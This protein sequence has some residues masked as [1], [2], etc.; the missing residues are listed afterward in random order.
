MNVEAYGQDFLEK[1][2]DGTVFLSSPESKGWIARQERTPT[3]AEHPG[4]AVRW[5]GNV[6][7]VLEAHPLSDGRI[8][9]KL[10]PWDF[11]HAIRVL[12]PYDPLAEQQRGRERARRQDSIWKRR[13]AILFSP[14]LGHLPGRVQ[15]Q[16]ESEFGAPAVAMTIVS[17]LPLLA[18]GV[19]GV[20]SHLVSGFGGSLL[21]AG[22]AA[23]MPPLAP[24]EPPLPIAFY[25]LFESGSRLGS[26]FVTG[27]PIGS[28]A[29]VL[30]YHLWSRRSGR[31]V[32]SPLSTAGAPATKPQAREDRYRMLEPVL[33]L[34]SP[35]DQ[36]LLE[37]RFGFESL[38]WGRIT[39]VCLLVLSGLGVLT[40]LAALLEGA[41]NLG[42]LLV[43]LLGAGLL[44]EQ[45]RRQR[46]FARGHPAGSV[47]GRFVRPLARELLWQTGGS[48]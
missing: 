26:T 6:F 38:R 39:A 14:V 16:M 29:G 24:W 13:L 7:E 46:E 30:A 21:A 31:R 35:E 42:D 25:L 12:Q 17:A 48:E 19:I 28:V 27:H 15:Q 9:Y 45:V 43:L 36:R 2:P 22:G 10:G 40:A 8:R 11:R 41:G 37:H 33:A 23:R 18:L 47:L 4:T 32:V 34:L 20:L 5:Q 44:L 1:V 3:R